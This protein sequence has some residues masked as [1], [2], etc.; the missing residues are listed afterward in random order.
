[1][2]EHQHHTSLTQHNVNM[3]IVLATK[4]LTALFL[5]IIQFLLPLRPKITKRAHLRQLL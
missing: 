3:R 1:M 2:L 4:T 5:Y